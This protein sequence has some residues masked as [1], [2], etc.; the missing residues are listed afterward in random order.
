MQISDRK[1]GSLEAWKLGLAARLHEDTKLRKGLGTSP[2]GPA[3]LTAVPIPCA[4]VVSWKAAPPSPHRGA[5]ASPVRQCL[6]HRALVARS[7]LRGASPSPHR[8]APESPVSPASPVAALGRHYGTSQTCRGCRE[9]FSLPGRGAAP[10]SQSANLLI[11]QSANSLRG[12]SCP[13]CFPKTLHR[14]PS[15]CPSR[16]CRALRGRGRFGAS[17]LHAPFSVLRSP[18]RTSR[19]C[20]P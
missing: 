20:A 4:P 13:S 17:R 3:G 14:C 8:G 2:F 16:A 6:A 12:S 11:S 7:V 9:N 18:E 10:H 5:P 15:L 19:R 1:L